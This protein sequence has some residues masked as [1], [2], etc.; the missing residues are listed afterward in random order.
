MRSLFP[1]IQI[2]VMR[3]LVPRW[4][5]Q[6]TQG[7]R[8][9]AAHLH[10]HIY[11]HTN[12]HTPALSWLESYTH[13]L[14]N[15]GAHSSH[16]AKCAHLES[17]SLEVKTYTEEYYSQENELLMSKG[18]MYVRGTGGHIPVWTPLTQ[19]NEQ[20]ALSR[21][22][23]EPKKLFYYY[24][25]NKR[26]GESVCV[27]R[28]F[29]R[30]TS[31]ASR[32]CRHSYQRVPAHERSAWSPTCVS[33]ERWTVLLSILS[34]KKRKIQNQP[35]CHHEPIL[36]PPLSKSI[37]PAL[38]LPA[39]FSVPPLPPSHS[40]LSNSSLSSFSFSYF[41]IFQHFPSLVH[42]SS[43]FSLPPPFSSHTKEHKLFLFWQAS[44]N[45]ITKMHNC[46][47]KMPGC[48]DYHKLCLSCGFS[49]RKKK[50]LRVH[51]EKPKIK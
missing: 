6:G 39:S 27:C 35:W 37:T 1:H 36:N 17:S 34:S 3:S 19:T 45:W 51:E 20:K 26:G 31:G 8:H 29:L 42:V 33:N 4:D 22:K 47:P 46:L 24:R 25:R 7:Q 50:M 14:W 10:K 12:V 43:F 21:D 15:E 18:E 40:C 48:S 16:L 28:H 5:G 2:D 41:R 38:P 13:I 49:G 30:I 11:A 9:T 44:S 32:V 23:R